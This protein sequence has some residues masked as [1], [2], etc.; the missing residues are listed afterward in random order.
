MKQLNF[1]SC[2][3]QNWDKGVKGGAMEAGP[4][5][6]GGG[7]YCW[8]AST[9]TAQVKGTVEREEPDSPKYRAKVSPPHLRL[10]R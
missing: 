2:G 8:L 3:L 1:V 7:G 9:N 6:K 5:E 10:P 4:Q